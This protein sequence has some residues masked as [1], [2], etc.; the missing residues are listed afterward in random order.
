MLTRRAREIFHQI[1]QARFEVDT[2]TSGLFGRLAIGA[3][4]TVLPVAAPDVVMEIK[5][6]APQVTVTLFEATSDRLFPMLEDGAL[7]FVL[8]RSGPPPTTAAKFAARE[9]LT[10]PIVI[11]CGR[12]HPLAD[13]RQV[14]PADLTGLPWILPPR[15]APVYLTLQIWL[16]SMGIALPD[17]CVH[18][19]SHETNEALLRGYPFLG[20]MPTAAAKRGEARGSLRIVRVP[21]TTFLETVT[22]YYRRD[23]ESELMRTALECFDILEDRLR[24][25]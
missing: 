6:R 18:S 16:Q 14:Q 13:R 1:E 4:A 19:I 15:E 24:A 7:D 22:L 12:D 17:G 20:L 25:S 9:L 11:V 3:V 8:S 23:A 10:D 21:D 2:L 5:K